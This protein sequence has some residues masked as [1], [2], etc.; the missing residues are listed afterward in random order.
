MTDPRVSRRQ[1]L[2]GGIGGAAA[3]GLAALG[4]L[5]SSGADTVR[6]A[7]K[8]QAAGTDLG[9]VEHV[10]FLMMENRSFDH[11]FGTMSGVRGFDD[12]PVGNNGV[13][14]QSW[15]GGASPTLLPYR[16]DTDNS[17]SECTYRPEPQLAAPTPVLEQRGHGQLRVHSRLRL[18]MRVQPS[19]R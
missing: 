11:F 4:G 18:R 1:V 3:V 9:A 17:Q 13:F 2:A 16:L 19:A 7:S 10:V 12:H 5:Q 15:P 8:V 14:A 6:R